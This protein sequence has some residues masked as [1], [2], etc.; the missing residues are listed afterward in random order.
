MGKKLVGPQKQDVDAGRDQCMLPI[1]FG[2]LSCQFTE[3]PA[4]AVI[5]IIISSSSSSSSSCCC[6]NYLLC[7]VFTFIYLK[8]SMFLVYIVLQLF[9]SYIIIIIIIIWIRITVAFHIP[10]FSRANTA[11]IQ[12]FDS[13][14]YFSKQ[15]N[16]CMLQ[17]CVA[18]EQ[19][20]R[21]W[22]NICWECTVVECWGK[23]LEIKMD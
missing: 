17:F 20:Y 15:G 13:V 2:P 4:L 11:E 12:I 7:I 23:C 1:A 9:S 16:V 19:G 18:D 8:Q 14:S 6:C 21:L 3:L 5:I 22:R 10:P